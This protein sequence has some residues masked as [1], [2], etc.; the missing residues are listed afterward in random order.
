MK[1]TNRTLIAHR[2]LGLTIVFL[3]GGCVAPREKKG[4]ELGQLQ[5]LNTGYALL[6]DSLSQQKHFEKLLW[7]KLESKELE[8]VV[9]RI[10]GMATEAEA[11]LEQLA[12]RWPEIT[13]QSPQKISRVEAEARSSMRRDRTK[14]L[15]AAKGKA[16]ERLLLFSESGVINQERHL[17]RALLKLEE[18]KERASVLDGISEKLD[19][20]YNELWDFLET[21]YFK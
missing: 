13:L 17:T 4:H 11:Q 8:R 18:N 16:F 1:F 9:E 14:M 19:Q 2:Y 7:I 21:R 12:K 15:L 20:A 5:E 6:H 10:T 3:L